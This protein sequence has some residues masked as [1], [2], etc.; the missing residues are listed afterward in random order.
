MKEREAVESL[1]PA[2]AGE[3]AI[4]DDLT[5]SG[6]AGPLARRDNEFAKGRIRPGRRGDRGG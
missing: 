5:A 6:L 2:T 1:S 4:C 3:S